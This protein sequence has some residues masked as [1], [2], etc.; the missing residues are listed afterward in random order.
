MQEDKAVP[1][2]C[3]HGQLVGH[4]DHTDI[5]TIRRPVWSH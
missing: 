5:G 3:M 4:Y 2:H 1:S